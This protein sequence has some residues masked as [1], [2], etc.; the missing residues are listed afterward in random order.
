LVGARCCLWFGSRSLGAVSP[1][2]GTC[3]APRGGDSVVRSPGELRF[4]QGRLRCHVPVG[5]LNTRLS[6]CCGSNHSSD[7]RN[8]TG[9]PARRL[10]VIETHAAFPLL[11]HCSTSDRRYRTHRVP[12]GFVSGFGPRPVRRHSL[13]QDIDTSNNSATWEGRSSSS[14]TSATSA[15]KRRRRARWVCRA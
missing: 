6:R 5:V 4:H 10:R 9:T 11:I 8:L 1:R 15:T 7:R 12:S 2:R 13:R 3:S 14:L